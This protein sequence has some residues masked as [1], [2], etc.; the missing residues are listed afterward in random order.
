MRPTTSSFYATSCETTGALTASLCPT[1]SAPTTPQARSR[2]GSTCQCPDPPPSMA[3]T[4]WQLCKKVVSVKPASTNESK[5]CCGSSSARAPTNAPYHRSSRPL[6]TPTSV[7]WCVMRQRLGQCSCATSTRRCHSKSAVCRR[8]P[9]SARMLASHAR[10]VVDHRACRPSSRCRCSTGSPSD[11][12]L[13][14]FVIA[15]ASR[16]TNLHQ[17]LMMI[18]C[19]HPTAK[20][21]GVWSTTTVTKCKAHRD[22]STSRG[23]RHSRISAQHRP[24][25]TRLIS[26]SW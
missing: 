21:A 1:G 11:T 20:W 10:R 26:P 18:R 7:Q 13:M 8:L 5:P 23:N 17:S 19:A 12:E 4:C 6:T 14:Q 2:L 22:E 24:G 3:A 9:S 16:S 15:G 25:L